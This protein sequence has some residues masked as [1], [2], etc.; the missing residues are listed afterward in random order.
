MNGLARQQMALGGTGHAPRSSVLQTATPRSSAAGAGASFYPTPAFQN[1]V[2]QLS[3]SGNLM[4]RESPC[5]FIPEHEYDNNNQTELIE[6]SELEPTNGFGTAFNS[7]T[8]Q[9]MLLSPTSTG[10]PHHEQGGHHA[11]MSLQAFTPMASL[12]DHQNLDWDPFG[13][14]ASMAFPNNQFPFDQTT[15]R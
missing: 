8:T 13:L 10:P 12:M 3:E 1:H 9:P 11:P 4:P 14:S 15:L 7:D 5:S 2:E 6:E